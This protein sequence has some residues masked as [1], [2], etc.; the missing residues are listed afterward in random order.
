MTPPGPPSDAHAPGA[1]PLLQAWRASGAWRL[2][3]ARF[4]SLEALARR[5]AG[6]PAAVLE[7]LQDTLANGLADY[8]RRLAAAPQPPDLTPAGPTGQPPGQRPARPACGY[9]LLAQ[10]NANIRQARAGRAA[11]GDE[12]SSVQGFRE[13]WSRLHAQEQVE[14][15]VARK[16]VQAGPLNSQVLALDALALMGEVSPGYLRRF[17]LY[18]ESLQWL[19]A[20]AAQAR[21]PAGKPGAQRRPATPKR[22][23]RPRG[24]AA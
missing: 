11:A 7:R 16:P 8:A 10:L 17:M 18:V 19:E 6:Q 3:P 21:T 24:R 13:A 12:L 4:H 14:R 15:A 9:P 2:D 5:M 1:Q 23:P 20:A 22:P